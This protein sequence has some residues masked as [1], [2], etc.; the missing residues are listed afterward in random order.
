MPRKTLL[1]LLTLITVMIPAACAKT[2][3]PAPIGETG[4]PIPFEEVQ[5]APSNVAREGY[6]VASSS[7]YDKGYSNLY[8]NDGDLSRGF[9][10]TGNRETTPLHPTI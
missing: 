9:P 5:L 7:K 3:P 4:T 8:I 2:T 1:I 10:P 6:A